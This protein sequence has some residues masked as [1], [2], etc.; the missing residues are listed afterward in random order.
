[1]WNLEQGW[2]VERDGGNYVLSGASDADGYFA[3]HTKGYWHDFPGWTD[4]RMRV[5]IRLVEPESVVHLNFRMSK[6]GRYYVGVRAKGIY[7]HKDAGSNVNQPLYVNH[8]LSHSPSGWHIIDIVAEGPHIQV[9][10]DGVR[11]VN[12]FDEEPLTSG[13]IAFET[14]PPEAVV[15]LDDIVVIGRPRAL[16]GPPSADGPVNIQIIHDGQSL[17]HVLKKGLP[18]GAEVK[19]P[20]RTKAIIGFP[21]GSVIRL[22]PRTR[23]TI[24]SVRFWLGEI[25]ASVVGGK[26]KVKGKYFETEQGGTTF[27]VNGSAS[28][29]ST[30]TVIEGNI[31]LK[32]NERPGESIYLGALRELSIAGD[33]T[34]GEVEQVSTEKHRAIIG[35]INALQQEQAEAEKTTLVF[36][37]MLVGLQQKEAQVALS[38]AGLQQGKVSRTT[39]GELPI[40][41]VV[42]HEPSWRESVK[43]RSSV[44]LWIKAE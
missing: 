17:K 28:G 14:L 26:R 9:F 44:H 6:E 2:R 37:P 11:E 22:M 40:G 21:E 38:R 13:T 7:F 43:R 23:I 32:L 31:R 19:T 16:T 33:G 36:V 29:Q 10:V 39:E 25:I 1:M 15:H 8:D 41:T 27:A 3:I 12:V 30:V 42:R 35:R 4:F 24:E 20:A 18:P 34:A 5:R